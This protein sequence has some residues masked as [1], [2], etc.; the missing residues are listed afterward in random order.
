MKERL[1]KSMFP[2]RGS[3]PTLYTTRNADIIIDKQ[4]GKEYLKDKPILF[5][6]KD[7]PFP[8]AIEETDPERWEFV[9]LKRDGQVSTNDYMREIAVNSLFRR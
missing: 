2:L 8:P 3:N 5:K 1:I 7:G 6:K 4:T 9:L